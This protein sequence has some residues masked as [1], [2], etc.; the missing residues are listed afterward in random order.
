MVFLIF[1]IP[2]FYRFTVNHTNRKVSGM[3]GKKMFL[4]LC[5]R[6]AKVWNYKQKYILKLRVNK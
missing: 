5:K 3:N 1:E 4:L 2:D 6:I